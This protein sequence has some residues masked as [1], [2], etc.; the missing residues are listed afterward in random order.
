V[1]ELATE[2]GDNKS[3]V[4]VETNNV[5]ESTTNEGTGTWNASID[6]WNLK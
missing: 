4:A 3:P 1:P 2:A 5:V 6:G